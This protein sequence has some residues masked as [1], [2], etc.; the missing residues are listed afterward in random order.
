MYFSY[1]PAWRFVLG[2][3]AVP[4]A[5]QLVLLPFCVDSP[6]YLARNGRGSEAR[7]ALQSLRGYSAPGIERELN[8]YHADAAEEA[9]SPHRHGSDD[10]EGLIGA[11][12]MVPGYGVAEE[13]ASVKPAVGS[14]SVLDIFK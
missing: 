10:E 4:A 8:S 14:L 9:A 11:A 6:S 3:A 12:G 2:M 1:V 7:K 13:S 5:L